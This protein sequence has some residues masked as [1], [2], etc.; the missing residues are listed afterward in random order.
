MEGRAARAPARATASPG[1]DAVVDVVERRLQVG[2]D[3]AG[4]EETVDRR[5][6]APL[7]RRFGPSPRPL[8]QVTEL[9]HELRQRHRLDGPLLQRHR[10]LQPPLAA[11]TR[12]SPSYAYG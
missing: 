12:A 4:R 8:E 10:A 1:P 2:P 5:H 9:A 3:P 7:S 6:R 11:S